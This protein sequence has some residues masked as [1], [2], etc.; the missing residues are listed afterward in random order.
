MGVGGGGGSDSSAGVG[1][2]RWKLTR[3]H[4]SSVK[5]AAGCRCSGEGEEAKSSERHGASL[6]GNRQPSSFE[7]GSGPEVRADRTVRV[8]QR[9]RF[10]GSQTI[11]SS[12]GGKLLFFLFFFFCF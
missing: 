4:K 11:A 12:V 8:D 5:V 9:R 2:A 3:L 6:H 10:S 7:A 1:G